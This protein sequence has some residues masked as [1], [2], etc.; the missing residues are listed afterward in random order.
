[1]SLRWLPN[2]REGLT[3]ADS[4]LG[5]LCH[6]MLKRGKRSILSTDR[7]VSRRPQEGEEAK[8]LEDQQAWMTWWVSQEELS[9]GSG[10]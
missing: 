6:P 2:A 10:Y 9:D 7:G 1:V 8:R 3:G 4:S 5:S